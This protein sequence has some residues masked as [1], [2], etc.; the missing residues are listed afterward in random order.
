MKRAIRQYQD[1]NGRHE[2]KGRATV[3]QDKCGSNDVAG[4]VERCTIVARG[5]CDRGGRD[6]DG[7]VSGCLRAAR[8]SSLVSGA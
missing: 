6:G 5:S 3:D 4:T 7:V 2:E 1:G 8:A